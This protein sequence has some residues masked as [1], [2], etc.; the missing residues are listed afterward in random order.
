MESGAAAK[1]ETLWG[2]P[3]GLAFLAF[4]EMWERFSFY[5]MRG[6]LI[7]YMVQELLLPGRIENVAGM[8]AY[9]GVVEAVF[10]PLS[11]QAF[12]SQTF[13]LYSGFV[14]F[15]P[16]FGGLLADRWLG[17]RKTVM[18][19]IALM[20][21]GHFAMIFDWSFLL[22]LLLLVLG[23]GCLKGNIAAQ[24]GH[25][26]PRDEEGRRSRGFT[27]FST[28]INVGAIL[29]PLVCGLV[30]Q[31]YGWHFGFGLAGAM[32]LVAAVVYF[33]GLPHF[34]AERVKPGV[35]AHHNHPPMT[36]RDWQMMA[37]LGVVMLISVMWSLAYDQLANVGLLFVAERVALDTPLGSIPVPWFASEDA[38]AS[39]LIVPVL[40]VLWRWQADRGRE[41]DD[42]SKIAT[43]SVILA[44]STGS[45]ALGDWLADGGEVSIAFPIIAYFLSGVG[46]MWGWPTLL[47]LVSRRAPARINSTMMACVYFVAFAS[48]IGSG[49]IARFYEAMPAWAF[50]LMN[51]GISLAG[52]AAIVLFG[53]ALRRRMNELDRQEQAEN[54]SMAG[55]G[56]VAAPG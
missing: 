42:L 55:T 41:P 52:A 5:G 25:L 31:V 13:G 26:Y 7:L 36:G 24:V 45:L 48:G 34:A 56:P 16:L 17:S 37:L 38:A 27:I 53:A 9:R 4:T 29:G 19:G 54:G 1:S 30:A 2:H 50:W 28:G 32:M 20:T 3:K 18:I 49:T 8:D 46:F 10:G 23:S 21:A 22:A 51:S 14:Y 33:T 47:A 39:V 12:A 35:G 11:T 15:T 40:I 43:C 44:L 6:L